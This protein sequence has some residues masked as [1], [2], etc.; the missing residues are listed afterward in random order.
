VTSVADVSPGDL[1]RI[2]LADGAIDAETRG[3]RRRDQ[4]A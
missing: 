4:S 1:L 2:D 3:T